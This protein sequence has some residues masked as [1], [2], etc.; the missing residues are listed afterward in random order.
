MG[1]LRVESHSRFPKDARS[2]TPCLDD[3]IFSV[4]TRD[5]QGDNRSATKS[6][7]EPS[8]SS[9]VILRLSPHDRPSLRI[10]ESA[11]DPETEQDDNH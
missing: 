9:R 3:A 1:L 11:G 2:A 5:G 6:R 10:I 4:P 7:R 8:A